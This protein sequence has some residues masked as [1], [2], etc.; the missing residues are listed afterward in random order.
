ML[1]KI[2]K[3]R[4]EEST[5]KTKKGAVIKNYYSG[6]IIKVFLNRFGNASLRK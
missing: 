5:V 3:N 6:V 2:I 4:S 1:I